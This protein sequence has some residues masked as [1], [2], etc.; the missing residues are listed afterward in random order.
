MTEGLRFECTGCGRCCTNQGEYEH[1]YV[2]DGEI[3]ELARLL[4]L[5]PREFKRRYTFVDAD[6]WRQLRSSGNSCV[7]LEPETNAC[8]VYA[9]R[10]IQCRT[11][12]FWRELVR[13]GRWSAA[14]RELCEGVGRGR[15][16]SMKA[17]ESLMRE[18]EE[19]EQA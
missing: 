19:T 10:P 4:E 15:R 8:R 12:P 14:A 18:M 2:G 1:V 13:G 5:A 9:A 16:I 6:G 17:A 3:R 11:F 7:F